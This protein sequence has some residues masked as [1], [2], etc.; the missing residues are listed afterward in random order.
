MVIKNKK[1]NTRQ[2]IIIITIIFAI[3]TA[4]IVIISNSQLE[5]EIRKESLAATG[6]QPDKRR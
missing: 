3:T 6:I 5:Q 2:E 4:I 1:T